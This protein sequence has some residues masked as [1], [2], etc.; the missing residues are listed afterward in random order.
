MGLKT[1]FESINGLFLKDQ[2]QQRGT[3]IKF[4]IIFQIHKRES[5]REI[6]AYLALDEYCPEQ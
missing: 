1:E 2:C 4:T 3:A 6:H 5:E